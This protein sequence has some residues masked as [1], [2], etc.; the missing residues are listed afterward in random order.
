MLGHNL[1]DAETGAGG[2]FVSALPAGRAVRVETANHAYQIRHLGDGQA[3]ISGHP[4]YCPEPVKVRLFGTHWL[5][6]R[7]PDCYLAPG[8]RLQF[9]DPKR[10]SVM[11][12]PIRAVVPQP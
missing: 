11:T 3:E 6:S 7:I 2:V 9:V 12:S 4:K 8:M 10:V 5:D 1:G